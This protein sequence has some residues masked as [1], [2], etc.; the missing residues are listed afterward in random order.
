RG[1]RLLV[2]PKLDER[3][4]DHAV[5]ARGRRRQ[6]TRAAAERKCF[7]EAVARE[8]ERAEA[9]RCEQVVRRQDE[10]ASQ[11]ALRLGV[12]ARIAG[13]ARPL[14]VRESEQIET[15]HVARFGAERI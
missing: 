2:P 5:V 14:L 10:G 1:E 7:T 3:V 6:R 12:V 9:A 11:N 8:R 13:L 15:V 4:A